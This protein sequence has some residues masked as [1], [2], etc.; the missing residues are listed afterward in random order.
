LLETHEYHY[1][2]TMQKAA[3]SL[4]YN[5]NSFGTNIPRMNYQAETAVIDSML[6]D[7]STETDLTAAISTIGMSDW[8]TELTAA[9][10]AFNDRFLARVAESAANPSM[11]FTTMRDESINVYSVLIAHV[12]AHATLGTD[13]AHQT[14]IDQVSELASQYNQTINTRQRTTSE[15]PQEETPSGEVDTS[16]SDV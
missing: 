15:T 5:L 9:N 13:T 4:L 12:E 11:S 3:R 16:T 2:D 10:A 14:I 8:V 1:A 6:A 7:W